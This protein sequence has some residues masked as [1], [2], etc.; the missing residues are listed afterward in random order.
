MWIN[1]HVASKQRTKLEIKV[2]G[3]RGTETCLVTTLHDIIRDKNN[4]QSSA[5]NSKKNCHDINAKNK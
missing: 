3:S 1:F 5:M 2:I 4:A